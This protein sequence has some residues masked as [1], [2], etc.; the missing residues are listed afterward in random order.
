MQLLNTIRQFNWV[1]IFAVILLIRTGYIAIR[2]GLPV[3][4][5]KLLGTV[6]AIYTAMHYYLRLAGLIGGRFPFLFFI[7]LALFSYLVSVI[8]RN[9][10]YRF[11]KMEATPR[12]D[13]WGGFIL[14]IIRGVFLISL[15]M[16]FFLILPGDYFKNSVKGSYSGRYLA[17]IAPATYSKLWNGLFSKFMSQEKIN[18]TINETL[19]S[20]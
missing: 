15:L 2:N 3:E 13:R 5:F 20:L 12:L 19:Q 4:F 18:Q 10:F 16:F 14:G 7:V 6:A 9:L 1:D 17:R 11:I 8:L